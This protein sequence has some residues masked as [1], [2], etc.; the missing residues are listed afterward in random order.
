[1]ALTLGQ[2]RCELVLDCCV[3]EHSNNLEEQG[4]IFDS[5]FYYILVWLTSIISGQGWGKRSRQKGERGNTVHT[6]VARNQREIQGSAGRQVIR[7]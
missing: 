7:F 2:R 5:W 6:M 4:F 1:M 3:Q